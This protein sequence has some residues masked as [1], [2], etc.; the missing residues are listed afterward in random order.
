MNF[1]MP[2]KQVSDLNR[3]EQSLAAIRGEALPDKALLGD[4]VVQKAVIRGIRYHPKFANS[5]EVVAICQDTKFPAF[6]RARHARLIMS[7]TIPEITDSEVSGA[8]LIPYC[9]WNPNVAEEST[10]RELARRYTVMRYQVGRACAVA[11]YSTLYRELDL[12]PDV[13]IAEEARDNTETGLE[14]FQEITEKYPRYAIMDDYTRSVNLNNPRVNCFMNVDTQVQSSLGFKYSLNVLVNPRHKPPYFDITEDQCIDEISS[15][16]PLDLVAN[17]KLV[18]LLYSALPLDLPKISEKDILIKMAAYEGNIDRYVRLQRPMLIQGELHCVIRGIYHS[19]M[20]AKWWS[21]ELGS[22]QKIRVGPNGREIKK[23]IHARFI[24]SNDISSI[25][26]E[27][28]KSNEPYLIWYPHWPDELA[29]EELVR[30]KPSMIPQVAHACIVADYAYLY[31]SLAVKPNKILWREAQYTANKHYVQDLERRAK[32]LGIDIDAEG[33]G[34]FGA[35]DTLVR[36]KEPGTTRLEGV[37]NAYDIQCSYDG[38]VYD[39]VR[40]DVSRLNLFVAAPEGLK[41]PDG[42]WVELYVQNWNER[43]ERARTK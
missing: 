43:A 35:S 36:D 13:S 29:L 6:T 34:H 4:H 16:Q 28:N 15:E 19:T 32:D 14:I 23:A 31:D 12:L 41:D 9:I 30:R 8:D 20:F 1:S 22:S 17:S 40:A 11:G 39:G 25:T 5:P 37:L 7:N 10:Y 42:D 27:T 26:K 18:Q 3:Q 21:L 2:E 33:V 38:G 24:M